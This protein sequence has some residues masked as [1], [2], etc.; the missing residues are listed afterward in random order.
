MYLVL[1]ALT[2][3]PV[4]LVAA[5]TA[6]A[7]SFRVW[8]FL[9][10]WKLIALES[11]QNKIFMVQQGV[12]ASDKLLY[13]IRILRV[14]LDWHPLY[15]WPPTLKISYDWWRHS[16]PET[17]I[18]SKPSRHLWRGMYCILIVRVLRTHGAFLTKPLGQFTIVPLGTVLVLQSFQQELFVCHNHSQQGLSWQI[19]AFGTCEHSGRV[20]RTLKS[21]RGQLILCLVYT[22]EGIY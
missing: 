12:H 14:M 18:A 16:V 3:S 15:Y 13:T 8:K 2:S 4:S 10:L 6:S 20:V 11:Q 19:C 17:S 5:S 1:S 9:L 21:P 7:F 22:L